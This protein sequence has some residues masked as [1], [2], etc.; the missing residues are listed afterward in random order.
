M[1]IKPLICGHRQPRQRGSPKATMAKYFH[2]VTDA[3]ANASSERAATKYTIADASSNKSAAGAASSADALVAQSS[4]ASRSLHM[5]RWTM[6]GGFARGGEVSLVPPHTVAWAQKRVAGLS[7]RVDAIERLG[8]A[9][10]DEQSNVNTESASI[11]GHEVRPKRWICKRSRSRRL[12]SGPRT[13][14]GLAALVSSE[15][16][17]RPAPLLSCCAVCARARTCPR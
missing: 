17:D 11:P 2:H 10:N 13:Q 5:R 3:L 9:D 16:S 7:E 14:S 1:R 15:K 4:V 12:L 8:E 6:T